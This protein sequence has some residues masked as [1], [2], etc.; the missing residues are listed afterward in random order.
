M[1]GDHLRAYV[2]IATLI[3]RVLDERP[4]H[5]APYS[6]FSTQLEDFMSEEAA[7]T[8]LRT[9]VNWGRYAEIFAYDE[10]S[11]LFS[12]ENPT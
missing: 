10:E 6:R 1:F 4:S 11:R 9:V 8:T 5:T 12:L 7:E 2:P 3:R